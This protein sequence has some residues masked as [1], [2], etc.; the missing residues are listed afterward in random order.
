MIKHIVM[1]KLKETAEGRGKTENMQMM[2][3]MLEALKDKIPEIVKLE[4]GFNIE[5]SPLA[6]DLALYSEF[7]SEKDLEIYQNHP[8]HLKAKKFV[9]SVNEKRNV[10][11]YKTL[12]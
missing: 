4:V 1:W 11:D 6:F 12:D 9:G 8:E 2:K 7:R 10:V 3:D 5:V